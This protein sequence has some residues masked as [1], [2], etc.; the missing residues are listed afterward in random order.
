MTKAEQTS[1]WKKLGT[2]MNDAINTRLPWEEDVGARKEDVGARK[3]ASRQEASLGT[4]MKEELLR[5]LPEGA[6]RVKMP[7][8]TVVYR[9][10]DGTCRA[11]VPTTGVE[12]CLLVHA[13][14]R[15]S[16]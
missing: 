6:S 10:P 9:L 16:A 11:F 15:K 5:G 13:V 14:L 7:A 1:P 12:S 2:L 8:G 3:E 4:A